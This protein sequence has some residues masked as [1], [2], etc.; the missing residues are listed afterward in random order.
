A[1]RFVTDNGPLFDD[2][3]GEVV[4][5]PEQPERSPSGRYRSLTAAARQILRTDDLPLKARTSLR[6]FM[7]DL[8][9][10]RDRAR[11]IS[12]IELAE[13]VLDESGYSEMLRNDKSPQA[14]AKLENL[15]EL[16]QSMGQFDTLDAYLDHVQLVL[17]IEQVGG[18]AAVHLSTLHAAKG[19][20]WKLVFLPGW[21]EE[22]FPS[23]RSIEE[24]GDKALEE[25]RRLAYV[26]L[27]RARESARVSF[28]ANRQ[29]Y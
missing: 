17:D 11:A 18:E 22:V 5:L 15:K 2:Q 21:E 13:T 26:G 8:D 25:E 20:E 12:H 3:T 6:T 9:R 16:I 4:S 27:T 24:S 23:R 7:N 28:A 29:I 10:W 1:Q 14:Q 19:L